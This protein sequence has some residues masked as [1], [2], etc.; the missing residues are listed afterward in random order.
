MTEPD[1]TCP[2][3]ELVHVTRRQGGAVHIWHASEECGATGIL[4]T[5]EKHARELWTAERQRRAA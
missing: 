4:A 5:D 2:C 1:F 3:G